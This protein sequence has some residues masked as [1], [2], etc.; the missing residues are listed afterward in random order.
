[1]LINFGNYKDAKEDINKAID[2]ARNNN[3]LNSVTEY[4]DCLTMIYIYEKKY[5]KALLLSNE[6]LSINKRIGDKNRER[7]YLNSIGLVK[8]HTANY[9]EALEIYLKCLKLSKN[10]NEKRSITV[11]YNNIGCIYKILNEPLLAIKNFKKA[12]TF[13]R[14]INY[15]EG[16]AV[17]QFNIARVY[18]E[19]RNYQ[20]AFKFL[21]LSILDYKKINSIH[22]F[23]A[24]CEI[25]KTF[26]HLLRKDEK[27]LINCFEKIKHI[28][29]ENDI[30]YNRCFELYRIYIYLNLDGL[31][32][33]KQAHS[34]LLDEIKYIL[35]DKDKSYFINSV[36]YNKLILEDW[37]LYN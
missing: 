19:L 37:K 11:S 17:F 1:M 27:K 35:S 5:E 33:L 12:L 23:I 36:G 3:Y 6:C 14:R 15:K 8:E 25:Y 29:L 28:N 24:S 30:N 7:R 9:S 4:L 16:V 10:I 34:L 26:L 2:I 21:E 18:G 13:S 31:P 22:P 32:F 20:K